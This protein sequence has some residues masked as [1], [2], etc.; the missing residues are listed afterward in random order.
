[1]K[2]RMPGDRAGGRR[3]CGWAWL[4]AAL[5]FLPAGAL[6]QLRFVTVVPAAANT[7]FPDEDGDYPAYIE[8]RSL[9]TGILSGHHLSDR[10]DAPTRWQVPAG[11]VLTSGQTLRI[12]A[13]GK[14]RRPTGPG[15][16]LHTSFTYDCLVPY[17][18]LFDSK[19][20]VVHTF[21][22]RKDRCGC[23]GIS[24]LRPRMAA[25]TL[26]SLDAPDADWALPGF[27][28]SKWI[29]GMTGVGYESGASPY[30]N[31]LVLYHTFDKPDVLGAT[32]IDVS[33]PVLH[34]GTMATG[35]PMVTGRV[36]QALELKGDPAHHL[37]VKH[38][39]ELDPGTGGFTAA[40]WFRPFR[41]GTATVGLDF[42]ETLLAKGAGPGTTGAGS[43]GWSIYRTQA[44]AFVQLGTALGSR[45]VP[46]G[47]TPVGEWTHVAFVVDRAAGLLVGYLNGK[48]VGSTALSSPSAEPVGSTADLLEGRD[49]QGKAVFAGRLDEVAIWA[50]SMN[51]V[52]VQ[53]LYAVGAA[54]KSFLDS[55]AFPDGSHLYAGLIGTD[56][57]GQMRGVQT[58]A[59]IR[60]PFN[61]P[62]LPALASGLKMRVHYTDGFVAYLN[63]IEVARRN[64]PAELDE[65]S[66]APV[67]RPDPAGL[68]AESFDLGE[69][70]GVL[71]SG[72]NVL[73]FQG[74][75]HD[76]QAARFLV[77]PVEL[78]LEINR[79]PTQGGDCV[80][81]TNGREFWVAFPQNYLQ[82]ADTPLRLRLIIAGTPKTQ[83]LV[84]IPG[85]VLPGF[86]RPFT[87]P[88]AGSLAIEIPRA[89][90]L[91]G[92]DVIEPK[93][94]HV[95]AT[96]DVAVYGMTRQ[97]FTT[98]TYLGLPTKCLG[99]EYLVSTYRNVF[100]GIPILN[101]TQFA[102]V[103]VA[104]GTQVT[105]T[106]A[107][108]A[109]GRP[110]GVPF[111]VK[112]DRGQT[113]QL[114]SESG[115]PADLTGTHIA[116]SL[117]VAVFGSHR[118]AN[119]QSVNQFFCDTVVE[120][121][122]PLSSWGSAFLVV[123]L[124]TRASDTVRI[125]SGDDDNLVTVTT[126]SGNDSFVL[127]RGA[128][129]DLILDKPTRIVARGRTSVMQFA[130]SSDADH[131]IDADPFMALIQPVSTWLSQYR[132]RTPVASE[133]E[134]NYLNLVG[135]SASILDVTTI[136]GVAL[137]AWDPSRIVRGNL[138][139][140]AAF[141]RVHL[142]AGTSY[143]VVGK[144]PLGLTSYGFS[145][146]DSYG[147]PGGMRFEGGFA[148]LLSCPDKITIAC[149]S[150]PGAAD[151]V[152]PVPDLAR[153]IE[154]FDDCGRGRGVVVTQVPSP[155]TLLK[156]G[157]YTI[158]VFASDPDGETAQCST[159]LI[160]EPNWAT[161]KF[162]AS[163]AG[164]PALE[165]TVWGAR[166]DPDK[167]GLAN[168]LEEAM[169]SD[170]NQRTS[171]ASL[172]TVEPDASSPGGNLIVTIPEL[173]D[174]TGPKVALR[175]V[176][177][178]DGSP[179]QEGADLFE[180]LPDRTVYAPDGR[181]RKAAY[182]L[183]TPTAASGDG[184]TQ[185][186]FT[187]TFIEGR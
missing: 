118:C 54:G 83:G 177:G 38:H 20:A 73:A 37:R 115:S 119:V 143:H 80:K 165:A 18:G 126:A 125:L 96:A 9:E 164:N 74:L 102:I 174:E 163:T 70:V 58:T 76:V 168:V 171:L 161:Q 97:D 140:G 178:L 93:G 94:I 149:Q 33:G 179:W 160:V 56:V 142:D 106:P 121:L 16:V 45:T 145:E 50:R 52:Q 81:E 157:T 34:T 113:Y 104:N 167:D 154:V 114:R 180:L 14:D 152:A 150:V 79:D 159:Q 13:S 24:L 19:G 47:F 144:N 120:E 82:E 46:L 117:P 105:I 134:D 156:P 29:R 62:S 124:A 43:P 95:L 90:E 35:L 25:R 26:I 61:L 133:F 109:A 53:D 11:Y 151:C 148:P 128:H 146:F 49:A 59:F 153:R 175:V 137:T 169:G 60:V 17:C 138:P 57:L 107:S 127:D 184:V 75:S 100:N 130:N 112:L 108:A 166:A 77:A 22:D 44:G 139:G 122:L 88:P 69:F 129:K 65:F 185:H 101:G 39:P 63:G 91:A 6:A 116:S 7:T 111:V 110:A 51:D 55:T 182:R 68:A 5:L 173:T 12:F 162:G 48:R 141:A 23:D 89:T 27:D 40:V 2:R 64:A 181:S 123:P 28:D 170:P 36:G 186:F 72:A 84:E 15:G 42:T 85:L 30:Q 31:G 103:A 135:L 92:T 131:V 10:P 1:M 66:A 176:T 87:I 99:T 147:H 8:I 187:V 155:G 71:R 41:G 86:P 3:G 21:A 183:R 136:N 4:I 78:C 32:A 132:I 172:I 98:D 158:T 67:D